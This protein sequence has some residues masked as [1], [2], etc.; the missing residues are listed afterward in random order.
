[1]ETAV[2]T[3]LFD[4][5]QV[6]IQKAKRQTKNPLIMLANCIALC[7]DAF[8]Q[9]TTS[10]R[11]IPWLS[12]SDEINYFKEIKP[13]FVSLIL[14]FETIFNFE[15]GTPMGGKRFLQSQYNDQL[16]EL[17]HFFDRYAQFYEYYK[18]GRTDQDT[19]Y[20]CRRAKQ[21]QAVLLPLPG[22][23]IE[24]NFTTPG[25][26]AVAQIVANLL[27]IE[28]IHS[29]M[30]NARSVIRVLIQSIKRGSWIINYIFKEC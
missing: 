30:A 20:F 23:V 19:L 12:E 6:D 10:F 28:Y 27:L 3:A 9:L 5:L 24:D 16:R 4:Q 25:D 7:Y 21:Q 14:Y 8:E 15:F 18:S 11:T 13:K 1:M 29:K 2:F 17:Q 22:Y 26:R